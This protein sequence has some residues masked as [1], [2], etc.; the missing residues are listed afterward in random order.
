MTAPTFTATPL[1]TGTDAADM[2]TALGPRIGAT[3]D[4][5]FT[6]ASNYTTSLSNELVVAGWGVNAFLSGAANFT[7]ALSSAAYQYEKVIFAIIGFQRTAGAAA[8]ASSATGALSVT[9]GTLVSGVPG[10][11]TDFYWTA[12]TSAGPP[13]NGYFLSSSGGVQMTGCAAV[14]YTFPTTAWTIEFETAW[15]RP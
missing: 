6:T 3:T 2:P 11:L 5:N 7:T 8:L 14:S 13:V 12:R 4:A 1:I 9:L 10:P 15:V